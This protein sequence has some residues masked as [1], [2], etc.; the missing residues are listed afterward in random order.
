MPDGGGEDKQQDR[1]ERL[2]GG[3]AFSEGPQ[4]K[5][6]QSMGIT[7]VDIVMN[8]H[9]QENSFSEEAYKYISGSTQWFMPVIPAL[10]EL[11]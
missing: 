3:N 2:I 7:G 8:H 4:G 10:W 9:L 5:G 11:R 6:T 1:E